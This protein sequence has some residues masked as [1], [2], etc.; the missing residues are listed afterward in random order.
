M[1]C[2]LPMRMSLC[3]CLCLFRSCKP[4]LIVV[5]WPNAGNRNSP[6]FW[7]VSPWKP[8]VHWHLVVS[9]LGQ[10]PPFLQR[11]HTATKKYYKTLRLTQI[12]IYNIKVF[13]L[14]LIFSKLIENVFTRTKRN[15]G[16]NQFRN[17]KK[18]RNRF[19][20]LIWI[21]LRIVCGNLLI[22]RI[23]VSLKI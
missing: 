9:P 15:T 20:I 7:Q 12:S 8:A 3:L 16:L 1:T 22:P 14:N 11:L 17:S 23:K 5:L 2:F 18:S 19:V 6:G 13:V 4:G 21:F 10:L